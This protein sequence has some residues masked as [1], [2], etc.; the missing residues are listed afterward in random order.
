MSRIEVLQ[1]HSVDEKCCLQ[2]VMY[3]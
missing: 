1:I 3:L 2:M